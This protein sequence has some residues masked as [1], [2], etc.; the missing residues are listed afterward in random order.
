MFTTIYVQA[1]HSVRRAEEEMR[2]KEES[3]NNL[4]QCASAEKDTMQVCHRVPWTLI[5]FF[6]QAI[7]K[8][9]SCVMSLTLSFF[10]KKQSYPYSSNRFPPHAVLFPKH[11]LHILQGFQR[12]YRT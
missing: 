9:A 2:A 8:T 4:I 11:A 10:F 12:G 1:T 3:R 6:P 7:S 5:S